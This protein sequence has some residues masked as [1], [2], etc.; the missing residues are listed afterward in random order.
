MKEVIP[1]R[2]RVGRSGGAKGIIKQESAECEHGHEGLI[3]S[4]LTR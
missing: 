1:G 2:E 4:L 3:L